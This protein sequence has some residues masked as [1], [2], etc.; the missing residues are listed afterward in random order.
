MLDN[1]KGKTWKPE[2]LKKKKNRSTGQTIKKKKRS[3]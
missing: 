1:T 2:D 3:F